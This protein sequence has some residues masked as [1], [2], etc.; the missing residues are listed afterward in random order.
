MRVTLVRPGYG[1][2]L[3][4]YRLDDGRME[5]LSLAILAG[6]LPEGDQPVLVDERAEPVP[7]DAPTDLV[8]ITADTFTARRAYQLADEW[9]ARGV[10]VVLGGVHPTILPEE[11]AAHAD[12][13][14]VGD[15]EPVWRQV[16]EDARRQAL[17]PRYRGAF[18]PPQP[19]VRP[20][21]DLLRGKGYLP[22]SVVQFGRGC[23]FD[24]AYCA[25]SR[26]FEREHHCRPAAEVVEEIAR[27]ELRL[28]LFADDNL[29]VD[30]PAVRRLLAALKGR[31]VRWACQA[32]VDIAKDPRL[33]DQMAEAGCVGQLVGFESIEPLSLGWLGRPEG[34]RSFE[35]YQRAV[36]AFRR[37]GLLTWASFVLGADDDS[38][39]SIRRTVEFAIESR[40][41]LAFFHILMP[42][43]G[44]ALHARLGSEG[45]LLFGGRWWLH[46]AYRYS[47]ATFVPRRMAPDELSA[48]CAWANREF[49]RIGS[50]ARRA[51]DLRT[52]L[53]SLANAVVFAR[54]NLLVRA[55]ST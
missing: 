24:C 8:A 10:P 38:E 20:R 39:A 34:M 40:V 19:G 49:Y 23:P 51:L 54:F 28:V 35:T 36:E 21:R 3:D 15:A 50:I 37:H 55:T 16:V 26:F 33:L 11:A 2:L 53:R 13:I 17:R 45:R 22:V 4:G 14:V 27:D 18:G 6:M 43:P 32:S 47:A 7:L 46:P 31:G 12:A 30:R 41:T 5:P 52:H 1:D 9:R 29:T 44:T 42:Y 48:L 25:V